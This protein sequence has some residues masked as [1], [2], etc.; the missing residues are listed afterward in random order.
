MVRA[1]LEPAARL[2]ELA[3]SLLTPNIGPTLKQ[4]LWDYTLL[5]DRVTDE[6]RAADA[7]AARRDDLTD[8]I[9]TFQDTSPGALEHAL[10]R[11]TATAAL[12]WL[13][14]SLTKVGVGHPKHH[15]LLAAAEKV[16]QEAPG[17]CVGD[18]PSLASAGRRGEAG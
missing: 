13:V 17:L 14:A 8:W 18:V 16:P 2:H 1:R 5:L 3:Q 15:D 12:P 4:D 10:E 6:R 7:S 11:W 9:L